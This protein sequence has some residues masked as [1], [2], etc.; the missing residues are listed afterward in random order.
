MGRARSRWAAPTALRPGEALR[1]RV[2]SR[3][4]ERA[5]GSG[6]RS[7]R[8]GAR[9][10]RAAHTSP[11]QVPPAPAP[12]GTEGERAARGAHSRVQ[13]VSP[14]PRRRHCRAA[15]EIKRA[16]FS[17]PN[18]RGAGPGPRRVCSN[19]GNCF[20]AS[21]PETAGQQPLIS[22]G[23]CWP[24]LREGRPGRRALVARAALLPAPPP[25]SRPPASGLPPPD[26]ELLASAAAGVG[27]FRKRYPCGQ[28][29]KERPG[30]SP[31]PRGREAWRGWSPAGVQGL[32]AKKRV[33]GSPREP[34]PSVPPAPRR[35]RAART[36]P[37]SGSPR[38]RSPAQHDGPGAAAARTAGPAGAAPALG[39]AVAPGWGRGR[40]GAAVP[41][42]RLPPAA[43]PVCGRSRDCRGRAR[44]PLP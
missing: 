39:P 4:T 10:A 19:G 20:E 23:E 41:E 25:P 37:P 14:R 33:P 30:L 1:P 9:D 22:G 24:Y 2:P 13:G 5:G 8:P 36:G 17:A 15:G 32:V 38:A 21:D 27:G 3:P 28:S 12:E 35:A 16:R 42:E 40:E 31:R 29:G 43:P 34:P 7:G 44:E 11:G 18:R 26:R 6:G